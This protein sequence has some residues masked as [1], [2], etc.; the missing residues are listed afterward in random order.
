MRRKVTV[1][2][3]G[4]TGGTIARRLVE[5]GYI[6]VVII[7]VI[8]GL[9]QG[10][11]LDLAEAA[12][13][14]G[15]DARIIGTNAW[16]ETAGSDLAVI[17][18]GS[19]R[20]PGMTR[21]DLL[22]INAG[23]IRDVAANVVRHSPNAAIVIFAN[24]MDAMCHVAKQV[25][26]LP[27]ERIIGMGGMLDS[28][29]F[30]TFIA[31]ELGISVEDVHAYVLGGHTEA[32]MLPIISTAT[33]GGIPLTSLLPK[34]RIDAIVRRASNGGAEVVSL[35]EAGSA[36]YAPAPA[37][38]EMVEAILLDKKRI[39]PCCVYLQGEYGIHDAFVGV[40]VKLGAGGM[41]AVLQAP[42]SPDELAG[43]HKAGDAVK[44]LVS[45]I[46]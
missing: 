15:Y 42:L 27:R 32:T 10:K 25:T 12:P 7:D 26:G 24:P 38:T 45:L 18:S 41:E 43:M 30:R 35:L 29:R 20:K 23:I 46:Q 37:T 33:V 36:F 31:W 19:P 34:E 3:A 39:L 16:E 40:P 44:E 9:P 1:V 21:E 28:T 5:T 6:D 13:L 8:E 11:A 17:T 22:N 14:V 4:M 2:G